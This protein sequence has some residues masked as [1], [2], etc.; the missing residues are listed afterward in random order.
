MGK[1]ASAFLYYGIIIEQSDVLKLLDELQ[2]SEKPVKQKEVAYKDRDSNYVEKLMLELKNSGKPVKREDFGYEDAE[3]LN[4]LLYKHLKGGEDDF[5]FL[6][7][8]SGEDDYRGMAIVYKGVKGDRV[9]VWG[10]ESQS[11][12]HTIDFTMKL[13][14]TRYRAFVFW[15]RE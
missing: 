1:D 11:M 4:E 5:Y 9:T 3:Y 10:F 13:T 8:T 15:S 6:Y 7:L 2:D 12:S 14:V